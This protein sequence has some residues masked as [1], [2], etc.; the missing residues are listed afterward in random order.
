[1]RQDKISCVNGLFLKQ[2]HFKNVGDEMEGH[3]HV[4]DHQ[5][6]LA[7]GSL[8][9]EVNGTKTTFTAP[10][11]IFI[12]AGVVHK[13]TA[14]EPN[15][16]AYCIHPLEPEDDKEDIVDIQGVPYSVE[17]QPGKYRPLTE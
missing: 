11:V 17:F 7:C 3:A 14:K 8:E 1:M 10:Q 13:F 5:T 6:L 9:A 2:M 4:Y 16:V 12:K 15:T